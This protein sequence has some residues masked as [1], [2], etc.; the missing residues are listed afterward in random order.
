MNNY[1]TDVVISPIN[2]IITNPYDKP[3]PKIKSDK[4]FTYDFDFFFNSLDLRFFTTRKTISIKNIKR[5]INTT[6]TY[7]HI[8]VHF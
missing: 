4:L 2:V 7:F 1:T 5:H 3:N 8:L 6:E